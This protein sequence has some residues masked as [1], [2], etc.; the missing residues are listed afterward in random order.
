M[1]T[2]CTFTYQ[3]IAN[4]ISPDL[5]YLILKWQLVS[6]KVAFPYTVTQRGLEIIMAT[7]DVSAKV[8]LIRFLIIEADRMYIYIYIYIYI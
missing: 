1:P 7:R 3:S 6:C 8:V 2:S 4:V 5:I